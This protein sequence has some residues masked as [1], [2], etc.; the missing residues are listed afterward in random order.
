MLQS[1]AGLLA[2]IAIILGLLCTVLTIIVFT[3]PKSHSDEEIKEIIS[4][5]LRLGRC[6]SIINEEILSYNNQLRKDINNKIDEI[7]QLIETTSQD[8]VCISTQPPAPIEPSSNPIHTKL[9]VGTYRGGSF[10]G[11]LSTPNEN[12]IYIITLPKE[13]ALEGTISIDHVA[14]P[15]VEATLDYL[16]DACNIHG[17]GSNIRQI[18]EGR[19][20]KDGN[21]WIVANK[22]DVEL[23]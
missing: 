8:S 15:K 5:S 6:K 7:K 1:Y 4:N 21:R 23:C 13:D 18:N 10:N 20:I 9:F 16:D 3:R 12:T 2:T 17:N 14:Y 19:V 11:V 22:I